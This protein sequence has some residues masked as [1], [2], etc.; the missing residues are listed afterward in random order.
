MPDTS[1]QNSNSNTDPTFLTTQALHRE[2]EHLKEIL[3]EGITQLEKQ[4][5]IKF[6]NIDKR[7]S[8]RDKVVA[9]TA[10]GIRREVKT[11]FD[12]AKEAN[13]KS[14]SNTD[15]LMAEQSKQL[16][17]HKERVVRIESRNE[18]SGSAIHWVISGVMFLLAVVSGIFALM[19]RIVP[20][21]INP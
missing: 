17:D 19:S 2:I 11:A 13:V 8:D 10:E 18:G 5:N 7:F 12:S 21:V 4:Q 20:P 9:D 14:E 15:K 1:I 6:D 16:S 3:Q